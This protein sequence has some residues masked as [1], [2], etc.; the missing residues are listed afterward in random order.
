MKN[1]LLS[2]I[3][4][5]LASPAFAAGIPAGA[6]LI[7]QERGSSANVAEPSFT[8]NAAIASGLAAIQRKLSE[9]NTD[10]Q[11]RV[12]YI[13]WG[14]LVGGRSDRAWTVSSFSVDIEAYC[15]PRS[16]Q[17]KV[18]MSAQQA[19]ER[20]PKPEC[21]SERYMAM[22]EKIKP[23]QYLHVNRPQGRNN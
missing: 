10:V 13:S 6:K 7:A 15:L 18:A 20:E 22:F 23:T 5:T 3:A 16:Y 1:L 12:V 8:S 4:F 21:M 11:C 14:E 2:L 9:T 19:C 17:E